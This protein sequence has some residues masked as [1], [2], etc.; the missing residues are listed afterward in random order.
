M[1]EQSGEFVLLCV[2]EIDDDVR[3]T[4]ATTH[5]AAEIIDGEV[6]PGDTL[7]PFA[8]LGITR[9]N[10]SEGYLLFYFDQDGDE[11]TDTWHETLEDAKGQAEFEYEGITG[12]RIEMDN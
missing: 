5:R 2:A 8:A 10:E 9:D 1:S 7:G 6:V 11:V 12:K 3:P 4:G